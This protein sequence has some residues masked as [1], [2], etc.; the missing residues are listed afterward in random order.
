MK[1]KEGL[2]TFFVS[3][4]A[5]NI[6]SQA[7]VQATYNAYVKHLKDIFIVIKIFLFNFILCAIFYFFIPLHNKCKNSFAK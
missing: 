5:T 3:S 6:Y 2:K 7:F 4:S 1:T